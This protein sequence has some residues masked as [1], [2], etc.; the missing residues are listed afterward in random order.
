MWLT[1][2]CKPHFVFFCVVETT[3][4]NVKRHHCAEGGGCEPSPQHSQ[5]QTFTKTSS[6]VG[7]N[8]RQKYNKF[9]YYATFF[10][11]I[12]DFSHIFLYHFLHLK[13]PHILLDFKQFEIVPFLIPISLSISLILSHLFTSSPSNEN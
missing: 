12:C 3:A 6:N 5:N 13:P 7:Y 4:N 10:K 1:G 9:F 11:G 2:I 8:Q